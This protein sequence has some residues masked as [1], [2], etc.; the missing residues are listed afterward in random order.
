MWKFTSIGFSY[1][2]WWSMCQICVFIVS[3]TLFVRST[4]DCDTSNSIFQLLCE[5][6][7]FHTGTSKKLWIC[8]FKKKSNVENNFNFFLLYALWI[9]FPTTSR[10]W[11]SDIFSSICFSYA[12]CSLLSICCSWISFLCSWFLKFF[13]KTFRLVF[14]AFCSGSNAFL[15]NSCSLQKISLLWLKLVCVQEVL[16]RVT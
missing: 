14:A 15:R 12:D 4:N 7:N 8:T 10:R 1:V 2:S 3:S 13:D 6:I 9:D 5:F 16:L 11:T